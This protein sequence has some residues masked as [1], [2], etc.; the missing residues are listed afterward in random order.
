MLT[1]ILFGKVTCERLITLVLF[2]KY[3]RLARCKAQGHPA[4]LAW[5]G[6]T[7]TWRSEPPP[8]R[9]LLHPDPRLELS[10]ASGVTLPGYSVSGRA[11]LLPSLSSLAPGLTSV[12]HH[13][14]P[15]PTP[16]LPTTTWDMYCLL[17]KPSGKSGRRWPQPYPGRETGP[18]PQG[19]HN[20]LS[21]GRCSK[22]KQH[23]GKRIVHNFIFT[24]L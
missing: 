22:K 16:W 18:V 7:L 15:T 10:K 6:W 2:W 12:Q 20:R 4:T 3:T 11:E 13:L 14:N 19:C 8:A 23:C 24:L 1:Q 9:P 17:E 5:V 21:T